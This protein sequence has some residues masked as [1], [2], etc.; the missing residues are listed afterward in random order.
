M[1][2]LLT[3]SQH[4]GS[5]TL[6]G[7][8]ATAFL[9]VLSLVARLSVRAVAG[10]ISAALFVKAIRQTKILQLRRRIGQNGAAFWAVVVNDISVGRISDRDYAK[11]SLDALLDARNYLAQA[12]QLGRIMFRAGAIVFIAVPCL[13]GWF[14]IAAAGLAPAYLASSLAA[15]HTVSAGDISNMASS[16]YPLAAE[17]LIT[18]IGAWFVFGGRTGWVDEF[19]E[20]RAR[21]LRLFTQTSAVGQVTLVAERPDARAASST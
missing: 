11:L 4:W 2:N 12:V 13:F 1:K 3:R 19:A 10:A 8:L 17:V 16:L 20:D 7:V 5:A 14:A 21:R 9:V 18:A 15:L 6:I